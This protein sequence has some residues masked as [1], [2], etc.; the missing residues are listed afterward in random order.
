MRERIAELERREDYL[1]TCLSDTVA[2]FTVSNEPALNRNE[3][4][5]HLRKILAG[6]EAED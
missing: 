5:R 1:L 6:I 3:V 2:T 4:M